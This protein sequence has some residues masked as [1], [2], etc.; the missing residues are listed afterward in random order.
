MSKRTVCGIVLTL[1]LIELVC[2]NFNFT[3]HRVKAAT[4]T[5]P[6]DYSTIQEAIN[7]ANQQDTISVRNG[8]HN[9]GGVTIKK[10]LTLIGENKI[11][12][13]IEQLNV[14][15]SVD[16]YLTSV[17]INH[18]N[19]KNSTIVWATRCRFSQVNVGSSAKLLL[20][21]SEA[22]DVHTYEKGEI[23][24][25]HDFPIF[26]KVVFSLPF[27]FIFYILPLFLALAIVTALVL[28]YITRK[29]SQP[30]ANPL[31]FLCL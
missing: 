7:H 2:F 5:V 29:K 24:G 26:G 6:D 19:A 22:W 17:W 30:Q 18:L 10:P 31:F 11:N 16:V 8:T 9:D 25:F 1:L 15:G 14:S 20:S 23:L 27:G 21:Q 13:V 4:I 12:T 3:I 28:V